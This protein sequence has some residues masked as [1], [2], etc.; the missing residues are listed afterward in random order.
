MREAH[1][2]SAR[3][4]GCRR[5]QHRRGYPGG[6]EAPR[7]QPTRTQRVLDEHAPPEHCGR[8]DIRAERAAQLRLDAQRGR[9]RARVPE[10]VRNALH[11]QRLEPAMPEER[12]C[13]RPAGR[14]LARKYI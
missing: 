13:V 1:T 8:V 4:P 2:R 6:P 5:A 11:L 10:V 7:R 9:A 14:V 3:Q 12:G